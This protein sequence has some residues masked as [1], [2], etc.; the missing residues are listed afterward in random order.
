ML[1]TFVL[2]CDRKEPAKVEP[3][4]A[5]KGGKATLRITT[6]H[7]GRAIDSATIYIKYNEQNT[8]I[9]YDDSVKVKNIDGKPVATFS[10]LKAGKYY[11]LGDGWDSTIRGDVRGGL[12]YTINEEKSYDVSLPV[13]EGD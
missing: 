9:S 3:V 10:D 1:A 8:P 7:H 13:T 2:S 4:A 5:G 12:P 6:K 11:L